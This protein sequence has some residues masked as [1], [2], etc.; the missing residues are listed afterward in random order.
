MCGLRPRSRLATASAGPA[1]SRGPRAVERLRASLG[2]RLR[3]RERAR[4]F[5]NIYRGSAKGRAR[6]HGGMRPSTRGCGLCPKALSPR[7][8][9]CLEPAAFSPLLHRVPQTVASCECVA[10]RPVTDPGGLLGGGAPFIYVFIHS[11]ATES[12]FRARPMQPI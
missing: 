7:R 8:P 1:V 12:L 11:T 5:G 4:L 10:G 9:T 2:L 3:R 6:S